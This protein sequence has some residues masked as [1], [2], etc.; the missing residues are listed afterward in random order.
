MKIYVLYL[1]NY[2]MTP[3]IKHSPFTVENFK[4]KSFLLILQIKCY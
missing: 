3:N 4:E 1:P 2:E